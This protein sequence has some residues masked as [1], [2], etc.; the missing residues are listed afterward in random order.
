MK[1]KLKIDVD[2]ANC[3]AKMES[4]VKKLDGVTD[5]AIS[6][7]SQRL[8]L[9][10]DEDRFESVLKEVIRTCKRVEPDCEIYL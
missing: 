1:K 6:F 8:I 4:A 3:A 7:M 2:C 9:E 5:A 10:A